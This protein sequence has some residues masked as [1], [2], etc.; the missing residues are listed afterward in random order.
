MNKMAG[1]I[2][3]ATLVLAF[4]AGTATFGWLA[5][6]AIALVWGVIAPS[7]LQAGVSAAVAAALSWAL[8]L[9]WTATQGP[10]GTLAR[11]VG[12][13]FGV[14]AVVFFGMTLVF[15]ALLAGSAALAAGALTP[16]RK[17]QTKQ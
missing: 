8:L 10:V 9:G 1:H 16:P 13:I 3:F 14:P 15:A 5:I 17:S 4:G 6:P 7:R 11:R 12:G 2:A